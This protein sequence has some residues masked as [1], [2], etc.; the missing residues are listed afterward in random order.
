MTD[1]PHSPPPPISDARLRQFGWIALAMA[2]A[3]AVWGIV[4]RVGAR[5]ALSRQTA[6]TAAASVVT[7]KPITAPGSE[8][9]ILPGSVQANYEAPIYA[10]TNGSPKS[11]RPRWISS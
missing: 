7:V 2:I 4:S 6:I 3:L 1:P 8:A 11:N 9:L 10:R 5:D